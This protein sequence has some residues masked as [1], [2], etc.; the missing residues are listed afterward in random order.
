MLSARLTRTVALFLLVAAGCLAVIGVV[1]SPVFATES[2]SAHTGSIHHW[3]TFEDPATEIRVT[4]T[5]LQGDDG[6][7]FYGLQLSFVDN[8]VDGQRQGTA[9][10]GLQTNNST[11]GQQIGK[12]FIFSVWDATTGYP[13]E[14]VLSTSFMGE[15]EGWSLRKTYD[16]QVDKSYEVAIR[17]TSF[18]ATAEAYRWQAEITDLAA[19]TTFSIGEIL[20]PKGRNYIAS[21]NAPIFHERYDGGPVC[22]AD[23]PASEKAGVR[24]SDLRINS[25][26]DAALTQ[27]IEFN[28]NTSN[29]IFADADCQDFITSSWSPAQAE[30]SFIIPAVKVAEDVER[31]IAENTGPGV[32]LGMP[33]A[34]ESTN[35][36]NLLS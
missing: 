27:A 26:T 25:H 20:A 24:F 17:R 15:G 22:Q 21:G 14:G 31:Q 3:P 4:M 13:A 9:Y 23:N 16:W 2:K 5:P 33:V 11:A 12:T 6:Y 10:A 1:F 29:G 34:L 35:G 32:E 36:F 8:P 18:D 28:V 19:G 7:H 30:S